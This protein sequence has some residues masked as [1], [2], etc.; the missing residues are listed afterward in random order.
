M[1]YTCSI[2]AQDRIKDAIREQNLNRVVVASCT[3]RTH[4]PL[5]R[6]TVREAGLNPYLFEMANIRDQCSWIHMHEP[7]KATQ[8]AKELVAMAV[9]KARMLEPLYSMAVPV[10]SAAL[11]IG[12]GM[13]GIRAALNLAEQGFVVSLVER[14]KELGGNFK[15]LFYMA[16][17]E[18][19]Q[20]QL[21]DMIVKLD[22]HPRIRVMTETTIETIGGFVGNFETTVV[23]DNERS[24]IK[25]GAV[26]VATGATEHTP[27]EYLYGTDDR[28]VTQLE[29]ERMLAESQFE[30]IKRVIMIQC[31]GSREGD[32][33]YC[34]RVCCIQ[35]IKNALIIKEKYPD[36]DIYILYREI[37]T[38]GFSEKYYTKARSAGVRFVRYDVN[39][40]PV[41]SAAGD[42]LHVNVREPVVGNF[43]DIGCDMVVLA[44]A[45]V[46]QEDAEEL[47]KMLKVPLTAEKF[48]LEAH[49]KLRPVDFAVDGVFLAGMAHSPKTIRESI[50][51]AEAA[52][53]RAATIIS[54]ETYETE[55]TISSVN[56]DICSGCGTCVEVCEFDALEL[57]K[58][59]Y[60][61]TVC[62][63]NEAVC[64]GCG[65]CAG[66]CP[67][68]AI[69]QKGFRR[70]QILAAISTATD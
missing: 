60:G 64:K 53:S 42:R 17:G 63:V 30:K 23:H 58:T 54:K 43:L 44:P 61:E 14:E 45:I 52:A 5:F 1:L 59:P 47:G 12:G 57:V 62:R 10:N 31:V 40:K 13:A 34:S 11:V 27:S 22:S 21:S 68:G 51:Q 32:R 20:A 4:E 35:A 8:K 36:T 25:H 56:K 41:V 48:F 16:G 6:S 38:Y 50:A 39:E 55:A 33:M 3:P 19:P 15:R 46:P 65:C 28:I 66:V 49:M 9:A 29:L 18:N 2:D 37:R 26:V 67:S 7:Q 69:E 24:T 70:D